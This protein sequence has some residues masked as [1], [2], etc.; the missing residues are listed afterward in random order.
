MSIPGIGDA[1]TFEID[2]V[3]H[4]AASAIGD[5]PGR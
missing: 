5:T 4:D 1:M 3:G 2:L